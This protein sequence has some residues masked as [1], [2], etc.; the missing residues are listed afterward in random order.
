MTSEETAVNCIMIILVALIMNMLSGLV[1][2]I[3]KIRNW[4]RKRRENALNTVAPVIAGDYNV[5][6]F[7]DFIQIEKE[8]NAVVPI[9]TV[10]IMWRLFRIFK[11]S[12]KK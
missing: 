9:P 2:T 7:Q 8:L 6:N 10:T 11:N 1:L 5:T 12:E 4:I 3:K